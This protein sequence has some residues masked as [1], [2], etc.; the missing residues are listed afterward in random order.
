MKFHAIL[1]VRD[2]DDVIE[3]S[4]N[5]F[6]TWADEIHVF[7]SGSVDRTWEI[8]QEVALKEPRVRPVERREIWFSD[9]FRGYCFDRVRERFDDDDWIARVDSDEFYHIPPPQFIKEYV[10]R[11][12]SCI[13]HQYY[14]FRLTVGEAARLSSLSN[15]EEERKYPVHLRRRFYTT[16]TY[17]EPRLCRYRSRMSWP[18]SHTF[19]V[20]AGIVARARIPIRHY[21]NRDPHQMQKRVRL[22]SA[23]I[24]AGVN[25]GRFTEVHHWR[26]SDW[27][28]HLIDD[29]S[30]LLRRFSEGDVL[31]VPISG[32][33]LPSLGK[34]LLLRLFYRVGVRILDQARFASSRVYQAEELDSNERAEFRK[35]LHESNE[36]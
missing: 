19:P 18:S 7:D 13:Y 14:D 35:A 24:G 34:R 32:D 26:E 20:N 22:R 27:R 3:E 23:M 9:Q 36:L 1:C 10:S 12:E 31:P 28:T 30:P 4:L 16:G 5:G 25:K 17:S 29:Q 6:I 21:P 8:V 33:H 15:I 2:E 11:Y